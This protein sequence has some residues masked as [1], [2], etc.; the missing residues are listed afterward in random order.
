MEL[1]IYKAIYPTDLKFDYTSP[2]NR[3][4]MRSSFP[5][6]ADFLK[7]WCYS[8]SHLARTHE[9]SNHRERFISDSLIP[10]GA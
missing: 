4:P 2:T 10:R 3:W 6:N 8:A 5:Y 9:M 7:R 1:Q